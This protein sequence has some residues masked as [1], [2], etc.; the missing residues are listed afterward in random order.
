[1][2]GGAYDAELRHG[3]AAD[4]AGNFSAALKCFETAIGLDAQRPGAW[5]WASA[6]LLKLRRP[7][8]A[9]DRTTQVLGLTCTPA[10][11]ATALRLRAASLMRLSKVRKAV[12]AA[13][14][15]VAAGP[16]NAENH[17]ILAQTL[18]GMRRRRAAEVSF[19]KALELAPASLN[20]LIPYARFL[21]Q[22]RRY[23][24]SRELVERA[25]QIR[26]DHPAVLLLKGQDAFGR[27]DQKTARDMALWI[28]SKD[29]M[30][31]E[32]LTLLMMVKA[33]QSWLTAPFW[34]FITLI[35]ASGRFLIPLAVLSGVLAAVL[36]QS[37]PAS[38]RASLPST[39]EVKDGFFVYAGLC[40]AHLFFLV[41]RERRQV[42][43]KG[44]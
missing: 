7:R 33:R 29:A 8:E 21:M 37:L 18:V 25:A 16:A 39:E 28:L 34:W 35:R 43:L 44:Y 17:C 9:L 40:I 12:A 26:P 11:R 41:W 31:R 42:H 24:E 15:A 32:A 27:G 30:N 20:V 13:Q 14:D 4:A 23:K 10:E 22:R 2:T 36:T 19:R 5:L 6:T 1:V 3:A 38:I